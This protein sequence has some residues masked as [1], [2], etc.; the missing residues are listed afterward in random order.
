MHLFSSGF[1]FVLFFLCGAFHFETN[2]ANEHTKGRCTF[3][4]ILREQQRNSGELLFFLYAT[5]HFNCW[6][7]KITNK[8][9]KSPA[10][11]DYLGT[12][13]H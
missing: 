9:G 10:K 6:D 4:A 3:C 11:A 8:E 7:K 1:F 13:L 12:L 5:M 2:L